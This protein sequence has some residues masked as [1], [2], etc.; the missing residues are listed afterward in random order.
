MGRG[1]AVGRVAEPSGR[2]RTVKAG[3]TTSLSFIYARRMFTG[4]LVG[5]RL[6]T[7]ARQGAGPA[8]AASAPARPHGR[9]PE[10]DSDALLPDVRVSL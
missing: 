2:T 1:V 3:V 4:L 9:V 6:D 5:A 7:G 8:G 10:P